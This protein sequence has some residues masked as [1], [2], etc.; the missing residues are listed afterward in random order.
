VPKNTRTNRQHKRTA[1]EGSEEV[2]ARFRCELLDR[3]LPNGKRLRDLT[4]EELERLRARVRSRT[5]EA[6]R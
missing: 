4:A 1:A 6:A 3:V 5:L 2:R